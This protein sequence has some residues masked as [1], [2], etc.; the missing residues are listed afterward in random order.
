MFQR[1]GD[2]QPQGYEGYVYDNQVGGAGQFVGMAG[3]DPLHDGDAGVLP[4]LVGQLAV[5]HVHGVDPAGAPLQQAVGEAA[6]GGANVQRRQPVHVQGE[7][8]QGVGQFHP[9]PA[10][11]GQGAAHVD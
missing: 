11:V 8:I 2:D 7:N 1:R 10:D 9:A 4:Q 6:G 5:A 3:V